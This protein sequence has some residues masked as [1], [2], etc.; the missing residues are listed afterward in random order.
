MRIKRFVAPDMRTALRMVRDDQG[1][2]AVI[3]SSQKLDQGGFEV[4][5]AT[6]YDEALARHTLLAD[7]LHNR[8]LSTEVSPGVESI[9]R[10]SESAIKAAS[11]KPPPDVLATQRESV[12]KAWND[13]PSMQELRRELSSMRELLE[14][15]ATRFAEE[16]LRAVSARASVLDD[17]TS[18][19]CDA[20]LA[21]SIA[22]AVPAD[23]DPA[24]A[25]G[26]MLGL[27]AKSL[28]VTR[29]EPIESGGVIALVGPTGVGKTTT[30]AK[31]AA[32]YSAAHG[33]RDVALVT[34]DVHRC[35]GRE[36]LATFGRMLGMPVTEIHREDALAPALDRLAEYRLVLID[37]PGFGPRDRNL[38]TQLHWLRA[39]GRV[40]C[41]L[42]LPANAQGPDLD[43]VV[44]RFRGA[45]PEGCI[46][47]KVD[48][49]G[50]LGS[51]L[52]VLIRHRLPV[53]YV[54][55]GQRVP[56]DIQR[57]EAHRLVLRLGE[58]KRAA[59]SAEI[60][61]SADAA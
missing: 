3:L 20:E 44:R 57:A 46:L 19:G 49:T 4:V 14:R 53:A 37:T 42:T 2:D 36:Q 8:A 45:E 51:A 39:A 10:R 22:T 34:T 35:G 17:L 54:T 6:D 9:E 23:A 13:H 41:F 58:L 15:Q 25:R 21:R 30:I 56:E 61:E 11:V 12:E 18:Y 7:Q 55:D 5:A 43:E 27:M 28:V 40:R 50:C 47:T 1:P 32:R 52:S 16:R 31:L 59:R 33:P 38:A 24:R 48:E 26:I 29:K 60:K